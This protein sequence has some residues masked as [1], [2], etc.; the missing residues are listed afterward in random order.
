M[1]EQPRTLA[2]ER[3]GPVI[4]VVSPECLRQIRLWLGEFVG[5]T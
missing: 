4:G 3:L 1:T 2:R 5:L